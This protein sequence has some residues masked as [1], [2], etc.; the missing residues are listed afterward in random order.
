[1]VD[2]AAGLFLKRTDGDTRLFEDESL[3]V[4]RLER[5]FAISIEA[6]FVSFRAGGFRGISLLKLPAECL[7][8]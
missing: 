8:L 6:E 1:M 4:R 2:A 5:E 3:S 7:C